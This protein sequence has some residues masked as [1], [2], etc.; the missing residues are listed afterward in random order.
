MVYFC[1]MCSCITLIIPCVNR[2]QQNIKDFG[3]MELD[4]TEESQEPPYYICIPAKRPC[5]TRRK[6]PQLK[7]TSGN[8]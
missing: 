5:V 4:K 3:A 1:Y 6:H 7:K 8:R 2:E